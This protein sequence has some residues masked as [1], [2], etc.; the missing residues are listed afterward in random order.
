VRHEVRRQLDLVGT[1]G[2]HTANERLSLRVPE[3]ARRRV[4]CL[5][6]ELELEPGGP[7]VV[8]HAGASAPARRYPAEGF[9]Q[10]ARQLCLQEGLA[11]VFTGT[12]GDRE[13]VESIRS[14][15]RAP[16]YSLVGRLDLPGLAALL[17]LAPLL[18]AGNTGP[19]HLAAA[20]GTPVVD[21]YALTNPQH[22]PW[23]VPSRVLYHD[24]PC[25][26]CYKSV[27]PEGHHHCL[28]LVRP[29]EVVRAALDLLERKGRR[30][31][32]SASPALESR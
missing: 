8:L 26:H 30:P 27:C 32:P 18:I 31:V 23:K 20:A 16:S 12:E 29:E 17:S 24:V 5:L 2:C 19:V 3:E 28:R 4:L 7:W 10:A 22:T 21:L 9:A 6:E 11:A 1:V 25:R 13:L 14:A 15:M